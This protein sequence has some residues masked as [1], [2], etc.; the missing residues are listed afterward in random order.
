VNILYI[1]QYFKTPNEPGSTRSYWFSKELIENGLN[2]IMLTSR[3]KQTRLIERE[4]IDSINVIYI[5]NAYSNKMSVLQRLISFMKFMMIS[6]FI[7]LKQKNISLI[8]ATSTPLTIGMPALLCKWFKKVPFVFEVRDLWPEVPIQM[9]GLK[10]KFLIGV[11]KKIEKI[12]Y[13]NSEHIIA[14]SPGM[15]EGVIAAGIPDEKVSMLPNMSKIDKFYPREKN[16]KMMEKYDLNSDHF[17][18]IH[19]GAMGLA[20][21]LDYIID[22]AKILQEQNQ[23]HIIILFAGEGGQ[24]SYLKERCKIENINNVKF[25]GNFNMNDISE[26]VN[27]ADC[28]IVTF[29]DF[30]IL[31]TNSPNKLFDSLSAGKPIIVNSNGWTKDLVENYMCGV[32]VN[33][34]KPLDCAKVLKKLS[35]NPEQIKEMGKRS[36]ELAKTLYDKSIL[37]REFYKVIEKYV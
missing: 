27:I 4:I 9:G 11:A 13:K 6:S 24:E 33:V 15:K 8:F 18:V 29:A 25:L 3:C 10:N 20:N 22:S 30:P 36:R 5:R 31:N 19:F 26:I 2:V 28:S 35:E 7:A 1:H 21:G 16:L 17:Y 32:Y 12:I 14:L 34:K 37:V 23:N